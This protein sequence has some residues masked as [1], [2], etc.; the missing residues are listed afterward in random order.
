MCRE[1]LRAEGQGHAACLQHL[2]AP[3]THVA[4]Q[5]T[6]T[7]R[8]STLVQGT[9]HSKGVHGYGGRGYGAKGVHGYGAKGVHG[10]RGKGVHG[11]GAKGV[12]GYGAKGVHGYGAKSVHGYGAKGGHGYGAKG[13]HGY[14]AKGEVAAIRHTQL[15]PP[16]S[17]ALALHEPPHHP[18]LTAPNMSMLLHCISIWPQ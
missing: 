3:S 9:Q 18:P 12:H 8:K 4:H 10:Y 13:G 17:H 5:L 16:W 6:P 14:G 11:Y 15:P 2:A 7:L 1:G